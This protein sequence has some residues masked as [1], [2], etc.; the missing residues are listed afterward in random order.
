MRFNIRSARLMQTLA[1]ALLLTAAAHTQDQEI[2]MQVSS[3]DE[4][5]MQVSGAH[6]MIAGESKDSAHPGWI[7]LRSVRSAQSFAT[8]QRATTELA[9]AQAVKSPRDAASGQ[10]TGKRQQEPVKPSSAS[11]GSSGIEN[12]HSEEFIVTKTTDKSSPQLMKAATSGEHLKEVVIDF[13]K[14]GVSK[15]RLVLKDAIISSFNNAPHGDRVPAETMT[16]QG[17]QLVEQ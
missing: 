15:R 4:I 14:G 6:G 9:T 8:N 2:H 7:V 5:Y 12:R 3:Q 10:A 13:C 17:A 16:F 11:G 1:A